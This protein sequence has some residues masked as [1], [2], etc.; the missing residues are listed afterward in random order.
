WRQFAELNEGKRFPYR[1]DRRHNLKA[2][3]IFK[4][5]DAFDMSANWTCMS[6]EAITLPD[7]LY[8]DFDNNLMI[9]PGLQ[10]FSSDYTYNYV[11]WNNYRLPPVHRLDV[12]CNFNKQKSKRV[13][14]TWSVGVD[15]IYAQPNVLFVQLNNNFNGSFDLV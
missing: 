15:N 4:G 8:P 10:V 12:V 6:G 14:R 9:D 5:S 1:Y 13:S 2:G 11:Q 3:L 7:Q